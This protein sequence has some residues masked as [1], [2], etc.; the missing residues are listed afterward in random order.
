MPY[1]CTQLCVQAVM[2]QIWAAFLRVAHGSTNVPAI[3]SGA[4]SLWGA[5]ERSTSQPAC[6][7]AV[8]ATGAP[9]PG[10]TPLEKYE[11]RLDVISAGCI[12]PSGMEEDYRWACRRSLWACTAL[13][14]PP[15]CSA[16]FATRTP[17]C[18][19]ACWWALSTLAICKTGCQQKGHLPGEAS[20]VA[21]CQTVP[22][23]AIGVPAALLSCTSEQCSRPSTHHH[24]C[25]MAQ[26]A[27]ACLHP[28][29]G[30]FNPIQQLFITHCW[31]T[32]WC[33]TQQLPFLCRRKV[34]PALVHNATV[35]QPPLACKMVQVFT[36]HLHLACQGRIVSSTQCIPLLAW[37]VV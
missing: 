28:S 21:Q 29:C 32:R 12:T 7:G 22:E 31:P 19:A 1:G 25:K 3:L 33:K 36:A 18:R 34:R 4:A 6:L 9:D 35:H 10:S 20:S 5:P 26:D 16:T 13:Y 17:C 37:Q 11:H 15:C 27:P 8:Q 14:R 24:E 23:H 2:H 30:K